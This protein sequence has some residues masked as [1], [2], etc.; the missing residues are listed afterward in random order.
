MGKAE[1][2]SQDHW[3]QLL[4]ISFLFPK[5]KSLSLH[6]VDYPETVES[7]MEQVCFCCCFFKAGAYELMVEERYC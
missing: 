6:H 1:A 5:L 3:A 7:S 2:E 4:F